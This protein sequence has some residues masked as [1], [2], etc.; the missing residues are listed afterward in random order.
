M[1]FIREKLTPDYLIRRIQEED[2]KQDRK[3][4]E[5]LLTNDEWAEFVSQ[6]AMRYDRPPSTYGLMDKFEIAI[7]E[8]VSVASGYCGPRRVTIR[9]G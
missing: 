8:P 7:A 9:R 4:T 5:V 6:N 1:K 2:A 3:V